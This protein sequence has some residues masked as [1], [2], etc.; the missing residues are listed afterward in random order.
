M[1]HGRQP[2]FP[3]RA[4]ATRR[5]LRDA[6]LP[7]A[8]AEFCETLLA[9]LQVRALL[10]EHGHLIRMQV[11]LRNRISWSA[12]GAIADAFRSAGFVIEANDGSRMIVTG[13]ACLALSFMIRASEVG[14]LS[15]AFE[16]R[17]GAI[18][19]DETQVRI[20]RHESVLQALDPMLS[21][22]ASVDV[23]RKAVG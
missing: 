9:A 18:L 2:P 19:D 1:G 20:E 22:I 4:R 8:L 10:H 21:S 7:E 17:L 5:R 13:E 6:P 16:V 14:L 15:E 23:P 11:H 12:C 3:R